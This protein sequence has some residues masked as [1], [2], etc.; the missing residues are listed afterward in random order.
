VKNDP[1][2]IAAAR[3]L[4]DRWL[5]QVNAG[6][7]VPQVLGRYDMSKALDGQAILTPGMLREDQV[8]RALPAPVAA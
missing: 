1:K 8:I 5:E 4:R 6:A 2:L 3:E 7:K